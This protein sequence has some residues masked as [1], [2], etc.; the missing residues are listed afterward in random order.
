MNNEQ[1]P[2]VFCG[3][4]GKTLKAGC[5]YFIITHGRLQ[6]GRKGG[7]TTGEAEERALSSCGGRLLLPPPHLILSTPNLNPDGNFCPMKH[8]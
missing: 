1:I 8:L 6:S 5:M 3:L 2:V 4:Y 7:S